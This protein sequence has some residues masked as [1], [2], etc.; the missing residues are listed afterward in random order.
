MSILDQ[1]TLSPNVS[2]NESLDFTWI[3]RWKVTSQVG[4]AAKN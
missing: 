2:F 4:F 3:P 1:E